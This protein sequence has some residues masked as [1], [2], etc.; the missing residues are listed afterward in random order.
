MLPYKILTTH[1]FLR[2]YSNIVGSQRR[3]HFINLERRRDENMAHT[4]SQG[5]L[6]FHSEETGQHGASNY[7]RDEELHN[8]EKNVECLRRQIGERE[9]RTPSPDQ[10]L[11]TG[12]D[13]SYRPRS[14]TPS[15][16]LFMS[17]SHHTSGRKHY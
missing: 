17:S 1:V 7:S 15:S 12:S 5:A 13:G 6:S 3:D 10:Y 11:S 4:H 16:E 2:P 14:R 8:L 9:D